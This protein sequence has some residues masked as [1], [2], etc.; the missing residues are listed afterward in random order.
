MI[1]PGPF[2]WDTWLASRSSSAASASHARARLSRRQRAANLR[3][4]VNEWN[5]VSTI[6]AVLGLAAL[7]GI[8]YARR[9]S[10]RIP[11]ALIVVAGAML[12][13]R[14]AGLSPT[15]GPLPEGL[16]EFAVPRPDSGDLSRLALTSVAI[17]LIAFTDTSVLSRSYASRLSD[18]IDANQEL[19]GLGGANSG[20]GFFQGF[21]YPAASSRTP[22]A[23]QAG[24]KTQIEPVGRWHCGGT[25]DRRV[26]V[27][28]L[29]PLRGGP[30]PGRGVKDTTT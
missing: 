22:V 29:A 8:L 16:P 4:V 28:V 9:L 18:D 14:L 25:F 5:E 30:R 27:A 10:S 6:S 17:A 26:S 1:D 11:A 3:I 12:L 15:V 7:A 2:G 23:E 19:R 21:P 20:N 13:N 24:F